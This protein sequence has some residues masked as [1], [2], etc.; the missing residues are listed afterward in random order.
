MPSSAP[1]VK[2]SPDPNLP[3]V[4]ASFKGLWS[5]KIFIWFWFARLLGTTANQMLMVALGWHMY[6]LSHSAWDLGLVGLF[7]F[8]PA[9]VLFLPAGHLIDRLRRSYVFTACLAVQSLVAALLFLG[10]VGLAPQSPG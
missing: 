10:T 9:L 8:V 5:Q 4:D 7:Q 6:E 2:N 1:Q 3:K